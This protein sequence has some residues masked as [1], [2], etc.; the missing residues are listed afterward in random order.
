MY[1]FKVAIEEKGKPGVQADNDALVLA[2]TSQVA[3]DTLRSHG[4][5]PYKHQGGYFMHVVPFYR[6]RQR[7]TVYLSEAAKKATIE[8]KDIPNPI[9]SEELTPGTAEPSDENRAFGKRFDGCYRGGEFITAPGDVF[10]LKLPIGSMF[11]T[12]LIHVTNDGTKEN[13]IKTD[14]YLIMYNR[15][16]SWALLNQVAETGGRQVLVQG[17]GREPMAFKES[18]C[19]KDRLRFIRRYDEKHGFANFAVEKKSEAGK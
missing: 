9:S 13:S 6:A 10:T 17:R 11:G 2:E 12:L 19:Y 7:D 3:R 14:E 18:T 5:T 16:E 15:T 1:L 8:Y 4:I